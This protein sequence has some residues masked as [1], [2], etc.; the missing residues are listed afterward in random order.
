MSGLGRFAACLLIALAIG[1]LSAGPAASQT[2]PESDVIQDVRID[3]AQRI[4][5]A[6]V[7]SYMTVRPGDPFDPIALDDTLKALFNTGLFADVLLRR[8][9]GTLVVAVVENPI[10]NRIAFE[11]NAR[12][13]D[14]VL[15]AAVAG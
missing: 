12:I 14:A 4:E 5:T 3:G 11:G 15:E 2:A 1:S 6:T 9:G 10:I 7:R 8:E 13:E